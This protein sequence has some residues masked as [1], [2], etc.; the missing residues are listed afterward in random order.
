MKAIV[1]TKYGS[2]DALQLQEIDKPVPKDNE[3]LVKVHAA[4]VTAGDCEMRNLKFPLYLSLMMRAFV[5]MRKPIRVTILGQEFAGE[6]MAVGKDVNRFKVGD[7]VFGSAG[8][9]NG[10]YAEYICLPEEHDE[11]VMVIKPA[12]MTFDEAATVTTGGLEALH[13][14]RK[15]NLQSKQ[16]IMINGAGGSIGTFGVQ[17]AKNL[18]AEVT[19]V[20]HGC[21]LLLQRA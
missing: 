10:T 21:P 12:N 16:K 11:G 13:F 20:D 19:A 18:N 8:F 17:L 1:W 9:S 2:P 3:I 5:G 15:G 6:I 4:T 7:Q 14:L